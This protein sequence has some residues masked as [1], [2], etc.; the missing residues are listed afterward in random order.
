MALEI[1]REL[2]GVNTVNDPLRGQ[3]VGAREGR[4]VAR[5]L[6]KYTGESMELMVNEGTPILYWSSGSG[7][8]VTLFMAHFDTVPAG[9]GWTRE[10]FTL[11]IEGD[12]AY[13]RGAADDKSNVAAIAE[14]ILGFEPARGRVIVAFTGDEEIGGARGAGFLAEKLRS[15]GLLP[16]YLVNGDGSL[17]RVIIRRRASLLAWVSVRSEQGAARGCPLSRSAEANIRVRDTMHSAYFVA[18]VDTHPLI[19]LSLWLRDRELEAVRLEGE[20]VK[21]NVIPRSARLDAVDAD[22]S[23]GGG[24]YSV[25]RGLTRLV[26]SIVPLTRAVIPTEAYSDYGVSINPNLYEIRG[27]WHRLLLDIR[28]MTRDRGA[29]ENALK[30]VLDEVV[31]GGYK[32]EVRGGRGYLYTPPES[33]LVRVASEAARNL[34]LKGAPV[35]AGGASDSRYFSPLGVDAIDFGPLGGNI[36]GPDEYVVIH[37]LEKA[38]RFYR[39]IAEAIHG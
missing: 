27:G 34:G 19:E 24:E 37:H 29:V 33:S 6:Q 25:D 2:V 1:L 30:A 22:C 3:R 4:E 13:G 39:M 10:P 23:A 20:W 28:A 15:E 26:R 31:G 9:P 36:H 18:G 35:E 38:V 16:D 8:P 5:I 32:L 12:R 21:G 14:A 11:T 7:R 17:S